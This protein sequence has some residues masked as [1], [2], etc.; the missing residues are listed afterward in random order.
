MRVAW[1]PETGQDRRDIWDFL[2]EKNPQAAADMDRRFSMAALGLAHNPEIGPIGRIAG[3]REI[4]PH[5]SYRLV[6]Q[7]EPEVVRIVALV[8]TA[9]HWPPESYI[10][11]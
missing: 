9:R 5:P 11:H 3:T 8:H 6:Y 1:T 4:I 2:F 10:P 7:V